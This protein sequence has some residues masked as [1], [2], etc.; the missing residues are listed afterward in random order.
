MSDE[1]PRWLTDAGFNAAGHDSDGAWDALADADIGRLDVVMTEIG[2]LL[3]VSDPWADAPI[4]VEG[5]TD[6]QRRRL[7]D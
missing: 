4:T 3:G 7:E 5:L 1:L 2:N 6:D